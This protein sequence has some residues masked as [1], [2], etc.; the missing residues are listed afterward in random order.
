MKQ[1]VALV[2]GSGG[3]RGL[4]HI[5]VIE[6]LEARGYEISSVAGTSMG[7][8]IGGFYAA[9]VLEP[10][11]K[12]M[13]SL[14]TRDL[15]HYMDLTI[16]SRGFVKGDRI[17]KIIHE[18]FTHDVN[19]E[20]LRIPF[21]AVA[22]DLVS[23]E[24]EVFDKGS[25]FTAVR[26]SISVP[27]VF[28]PVEL[29]KKR[30]VDGGVIS[31]IPIPYVKRRNDDILVVV[32]LSGDDRGYESH[33]KKTPRKFGHEARKKEEEKHTL[34][35]KLAQFF[36]FQMPGIKFDYLETIGE[37]FE[38]MQREI[39]ALTIQNHQPD[40]VI[41]I[42]FQLA[43]PWEFDR[44]AEIRAT[45]REIAISALDAWEEKRLIKSAG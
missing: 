9:G 1:K 28:T 30:L 35:Q 32:N 43:T 38:L 29:D 8:M 2:L 23:H 26:A 16:S 7:A 22:T 17:F 36:T 41:N 13:C 10:F 15:W 37:T 6:E 14:T 12:R 20:K 21:T 11:A 24:L 19:I 42:P 33:S 25:L 3:A 5:G 34:H 27:D 4:A 31:P 39:A 18:E 40:I 45:G 44:S